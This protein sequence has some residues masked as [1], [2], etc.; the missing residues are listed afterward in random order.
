VKSTVGAIGYVDLS[1]AKASGLQFAS[2][3]NKDGRYMAPTVQA[4]TAAAAGAMVNSDLTYSAVWASGPGAYPITAQTWIIAYKNQTDR[5]KGEAL[6]AWLTYVLGDGQ[7]LAPSVDFGPLPKEIAQKA[8][9]QIATL[10][11]PAND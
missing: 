6:K 11:T 4:A 3:K 5:A 9:K 8:Q 1:D 10:Q 2:V 7:S